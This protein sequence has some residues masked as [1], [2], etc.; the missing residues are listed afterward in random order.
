MDRARAE[1]QHQDQQELHDYG[2]P[3][4]H[5]SR[6]YSDEIRLTQGAARRGLSDRQATAW[7]MTGRHQ[8]SPTKGASGEIRRGTGVVKRLEDYRGWPLRQRLEVLAFDA[9][10]A[11]VPQGLLEALWEAIDRL[12]WPSSLSRAGDAGEGFGG[13]QELVDFLDRRCWRPR[14][15]D[16]SSGVRGGLRTTPGALYCA[17][18]LTRVM[19]TE[20]R[21]NFNSVENGFE[22]GA[23]LRVCRSKAGRQPDA[24]RTAVRR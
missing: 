14:N 11:G 17:R 3:Q 2:G 16:R 13:P 23:Q 8:H 15:L 5:P 21:R 18:Q 22:H 20:F 19:Y 7:T 24:S 6:V 10:L 1:M 9:R 4:Q 12:S